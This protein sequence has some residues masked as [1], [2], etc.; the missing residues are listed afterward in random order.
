VL[1]IADQIFQI[2]L[3]PR[4]AINAYLLGDVLVD[5]GIEQSAQKLLD[6]L[7]DR[8]I[9]AIA[10]THAHGDH[11]GSMARLAEHL[12]VPIW[13]GARD[14][15]ATQTGRPVLSPPMNRPRLRGLAFAA[16]GFDGA[17]V[18][19]TLAEGDELIEG[20]AVLDT[21]GHSP[22]HVSFWRESDRSL[23]CGDVFFNMHLA[24][25]VPGLRQPP[26]VLTV[27]PELNRQS[28]RRLASLEPQTVGF[29]HG[30]TLQQAAPTLERFLA[31]R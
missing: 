9:K 23:I 29:G 17:P 26:R 13:C 31:S 22:G 15:D 14:R 18:A 7:G 3:L 21:P 25:T 11:G 16:G 24:T 12:D 8:S 30:P 20:F 10:L 6:A 28:E 27:D 1:E 5:T 19:R 2:P 4:N